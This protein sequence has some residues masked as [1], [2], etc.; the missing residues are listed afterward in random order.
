M[1]P[2]VDIFAEMT[3]RAQ[4]TQQVWEQIDGLVSVLQ[5]QQLSQNEELLLKIILLMSESLRPLGSEQDM[6]KLT[7][8]VGS[9][10][11]GLMN[12]TKKGK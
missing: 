1:T 3:K 8:E 5:A 12:Q 4:R 9:M 7:K 11:S 6:E 10:I 2:K